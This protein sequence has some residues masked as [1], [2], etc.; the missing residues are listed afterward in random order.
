M[1]K[2]INQLQVMQREYDREMCSL[3]Y[4]KDNAVESLYKLQNLINDKVRKKEP[5]DA[6]LVDVM[7]YLSD[8]CPHGPENKIS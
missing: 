4:Q 5:F 7:K 1:Q 2:V 6:I 3:R 8:R